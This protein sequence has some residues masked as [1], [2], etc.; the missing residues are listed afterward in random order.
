[1]FFL[2]LNALEV[3]QLLGFAHFRQ[4]VLL[5]SPPSEEASICAGL[6][7]R[8]EGPDPGGARWSVADTWRETLLAGLTWRPWSQEE[9]EGAHLADTVSR[10][11]VREMARSL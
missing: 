7:G 5:S 11:G 10:P 9:G 3:A 1:M 6:G 2:V 4:L 8:V